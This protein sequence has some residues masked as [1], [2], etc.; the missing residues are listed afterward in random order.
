MRHLRHQRRWVRQARISL[1]PWPGS[2]QS[3]GGDCC[4]DGP[5]LRIP[6]DRPLAAWC[7]SRRG[8]VLALQRRDVDV[9]AGLITVQRAWVHLEGGGSS[10]GPPKTEAG[11]RTVAFPEN[12]LPDL[13]ACLGSIDPEPHA[14]L[15]PGQPGQPISSRTLDRA[16][17]KAR[18]TIRRRPR[19]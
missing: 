2:G 8:E 11:R 7:Q 1:R 13:V 18:T 17:T 4:G 10:V 14:W 12:I 6:P 15:S 19:S 9:T 3:R 5:S 16:W